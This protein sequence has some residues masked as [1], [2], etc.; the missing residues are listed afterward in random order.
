MNISAESFKLVEL[1]AKTDRQLANYINHRLEAGLNFARL[2]SDPGTPSRWA[3]AEPFRDKAREALGEAGKLLPL[4]NSLG[5]AERRR[6]ACKLS[7]LRRA[8]ETSNG[9]ERCLR[10]ACF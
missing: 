6:L 5:P 3:S 8:L 2:A 10:A 1:R 9:A 4:V 7:E